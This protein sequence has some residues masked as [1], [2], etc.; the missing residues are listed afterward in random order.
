[1]VR[2]YAPIPAENSRG[3]CCAKN[4]SRA[5]FAAPVRRRAR[6][7]KRASALPQPAN[8][9]RR[10]V[11]AGRLRRHHHAACRPGFVRAHRPTGRDR[12]SAKRRRDRR[13]QRGDGGATRRLHAVCDVERDRAVEIAD[14]DHAVRSGDSLRSD[15]HGGDVRQYDPGAGRFSAANDAGHADDRPRQ[16]RVHS[17]SG[18]S[19]PA[20]R[21]MSPPN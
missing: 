3:S 12:K 15:L 14:Q 9:D 13:G 4:D 8:P 10:S 16:F 20:A 11:R 17:T 19:I 1:M 21:R 7:R 18:P 6:N 2:P 5:G